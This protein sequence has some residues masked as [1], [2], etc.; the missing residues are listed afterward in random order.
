MS[1]LS[2]FYYSAGNLPWV[3]SLFLGLEA[4]VVGIVFNVTLEMGGATS[5]AVRRQSS[6]CWLLLPYY[7]KSIQF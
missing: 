3:H 6:C 4:L 7:S 5:R 1:V 2:A